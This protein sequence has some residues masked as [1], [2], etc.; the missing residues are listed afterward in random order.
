[1]GSLPR[2]VNQTQPQALMKYPTFMAVFL[3]GEVCAEDGCRAAFGFS[4]FA[5]A[6]GLARFAEILWRASIVVMMG[7]V[8]RTSVPG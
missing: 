6:A 5:D 4:P 2:A 7:S 1:M 3:F 8:S